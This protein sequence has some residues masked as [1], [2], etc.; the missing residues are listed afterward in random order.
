M[1]ARS[2]QSH[3]ARHSMRRVRSV[4]QSRRDPAR[5]LR[6]ASRPRH[7][8]PSEDQ[9]DSEARWTRL[10][11]H[12]SCAWPPQRSQRERRARKPLPSTVPRAHSHPRLFTKDYSSSR[13][14]NKR[15]RRS[16]SRRTCLH[17]SQ[18]RTDWLQSTC[19]HI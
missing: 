3:R 11:S 6:P 13:R 17:W 14:Q 1:A 8:R 5:Q 4:L 10:S 2:R 15:R 19:T 12:R 9:K 18:R 16:R 7:S